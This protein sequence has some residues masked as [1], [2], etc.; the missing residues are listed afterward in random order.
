MEKIILASGSPRRR[1][2]LPQ[3]G[4]KDFEII[5]AEAEPPI[6]A[7]MHPDEAVKLISAAKASEVSAKYPDAVIMAAD[8]VVAL[9]NKI[10]GK[11][12]DSDEAFSH[13]KM[14]SGNSHSVYTGVTVRRGDKIL[15]EFERSEVFFI[16]LTDEQ[17]RR[18]IATGESSDKAGS[19]AVQ[20]LGSLLVERI[21]GDYFNVMGLPLC[22]LGKMLKNF[23]IV[24]L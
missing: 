23:G 15:T 11:P 7:G 14:L 9:G 8:T 3:I 4:V 5:P 22:L 19:Y 1:E 6:P 20:G 24:L 16:P 12:A 10:L 18:Y 17:I 13:L 21:E 2:L